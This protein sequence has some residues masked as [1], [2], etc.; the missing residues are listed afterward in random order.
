MSR[1]ATG[2][3][4]CSSTG[5]YSTLIRTWTKRE[6]F[7]LPTCRDPD[8]AKARSVL[9]GAVAKRFRLAN[10]NRARGDEALKILATASTRALE[11]AV[12]VCEE[13]LGGKIPVKGAKKAPTFGEV[14]KAWVDGDLRTAY[15]DH[16]EKLTDAFLDTVRSRLNKAILPS[17]GDRRVD[18]ITR[19]DC[20]DVMRRLPVPKGKAELSRE[21]R[22][23][24]AA[25]INRVLNLAELAG[26]VQRNPLP[27]GWLPKSGPRKR[28]PILYPR[29]DLALLAC[30]VV[31]LAYRVLYGFVHREGVRRGEASALE[32]RDVDLE[33]GTVSLDE[34]K[35]DHPRWWK[36]S[37]GV[38]EALAAWKAARAIEGT[39]VEPKDSV[40][41]DEHDRPLVL[42][43]LAEKI[44]DHLALAG[45]TRAD[46]TSKGPN[47]GPFGTHCFRRS[48]VT[49]NLALGT[50]EDAVRRRTGHKSNELLK[51]RQAANAVAELELGDV[52]PLVLCLPELSPLTGIGG[53]FQVRTASPGAE[54]PARAS[55]N[56]PKRDYHHPNATRSVEPRGIE[57]LTSSMPC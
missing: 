37:S 36:L 50:N 34:N 15:P 54:P 29:E 49:R 41:I 44:R 23:Q 38:V 52:E 7:Q 45:L 22:R 56:R 57:P 40:F 53:A 28:F 12:A 31:P 26:H 47:K 10:V 42:D 25:L 9:L 32:W 16:V 46:L 4:R 18:E 11:D 33:H 13:L 27:R 30:T 6:T 39:R 21:T 51:Y 2:E 14:A 48:M 8:E 1:E 20:D 35:T 24:Y 43:H 5:E 55:R 17:L 3:I 19:A